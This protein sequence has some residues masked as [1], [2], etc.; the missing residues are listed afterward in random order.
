M[1]KYFICNICVLLSDSN[2]MNV[3]QELDFPKPYKFSVPGR[4]ST[5]FNILESIGLLLIVKTG[6]EK[7]YT[8]RRQT[9]GKVT[10]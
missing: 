7:S 1:I 5:K 4:F 10:E 6:I 9:M 2:I 3:L 8:K